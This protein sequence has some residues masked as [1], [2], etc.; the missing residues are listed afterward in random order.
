MH[1]AGT[2]GAVDR[3][4]I[5]RV[6]GSPAGSKVVNAIM[7]PL[8]EIFAPLTSR[9]VQPAIKYDVTSSLDDVVNDKVLFNVIGRGSGDVLPHRCRRVAV[10]CP[11]AGNGGDSAERRLGQ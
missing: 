9:S 3:N 8:S 2:F 10:T 5:K 6:A 1:A 7:A 4:K 11:S